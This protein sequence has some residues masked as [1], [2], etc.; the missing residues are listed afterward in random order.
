MR[1]LSAILLIGS[2][3]GQQAAL[4]HSHVGSGMVEPAGHDARPHIHLAHHDAHDVADLDVGH[5]N[6]AWHDH[7][8]L[9]ELF[10]GPFDRGLARCHRSPCGDHDEDAV[11]LN[12][13]S[14]LGIEQAAPKCFN[15]GGLF[16]ISAGDASVAGSAGYG[17]GGSPRYGPRVPIFLASTRLLV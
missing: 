5:V 9:A 15:P 2:L 16:V 4:P 12:I 13:G 14:T 3:L 8:V 7:N 17:A 6:D 11:Y 1:Q 10:G